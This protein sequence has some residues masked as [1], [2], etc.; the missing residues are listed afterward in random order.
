MLEIILVILSF[1]LGA[2]PIIDWLNYTLTGQRLEKLGTGNVSVS[3]AFYHGGRLVGI[4]AVLSEAAKGIVVVLLARLLFP[5]VGVWEIIALIA[6]VL[7][8]YCLGRGAGT[9]NVFWGIITH[10]PLAAALVF[11]LGGLSFLG[12]RQRQLSKVFI[13]IFLVV[14]IAWRHPQQPA[15]IIAT[16][17][18]SLLLGWVISNI[19]DDLNLSTQGVNR[20]SQGM[21]NFLR[22]QSGLISLEKSLK[23]TEVGQK[24][25]NL[26]LLKSWGYLVPDGWVLLADEKIDF[27][28]EWLQ[29]SEDNPYIVRSSAVG[30]DDQFSSAAGQYQSILNI[31]NQAELKRAIAVCRDSYLSESAQQYRQDRGQK[32]A[33]MAI[34][35]QKQ[36]KGVLSG[37]V[38]SRDPLEQ[39]DQAVV[40]EAY[41]GDASLV[42]SGKVTPE[43]HRVMVKDNAK[44]NSLELSPEAVIE[45]IATIAREIENRAFG[46]PEDLE[47]TYDGQRLW[48]LQSR[49][50]TTLQPLWTR[51]IAAEVIP[52]IIKPLTWS[53]N[54]P[55]TCGV[56]GEIFTIVL[57][58]RAVGLNFEDT[59]TLHWGRAYFNATLLG[60]I[61]L[62][63]GLPRESLEFLTRGAKMTKPPLL[64]TLVNIPGLLRLLGRE[65]RLVTDFQRD[66]RLYFQPLLT[67]LQSWPSADLPGQIPAILSTLQRATYYSILAPLSLALRQGILKVDLEDL[68]NSL[69]PEVESLRSLAE[70]ARDTA[71]IIP[72]VANSEE[73][74]NHLDQPILDKFKALVSRYAYL[75]ETATDISVPR[76]GDNPSLVEELF[77]QFLLYP[78][79]P[80]KEIPAN[81]A[82]QIVQ[83][84]L[85]LKGRVTEVYSQLLAYLRW[86][87]LALGEEWVR[88]GLLES[89]DDI[90]WLEY[91]EITAIIADKSKFNPKLIQERQTQWREITQVE[92]VPYVVYGNHPG[93]LTPQNYTCLDQQLR[94]IGASWGEKTGIIKIIR[95]LEEIKEINQEM[96]VVVPYT[97]SGWGPFLVRAGGIISEVGGRLSHGAIIAREY[98]IPAIM[99][100]QNATQVL[101]DGQ[102]VRING[103]QG[104]V[105]ILA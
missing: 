20:E 49:P 26:S 7:G 89:K 29:V 94:G 61:F 15:L 80:T 24:A 102:R 81:F 18:L 45:A 3:A 86:S 25:A 48:L 28:L 101:K 99:D 77:Y 90:F 6:L 63:M 52:G 74:F 38:F 75:S 12:W 51:K 104:V 58:N 65:W 31:T 11:C 71:K 66:D 83:Q 78:Q 37:V 56:W 43:S 87:F 69:T 34:I 70:L 95:N 76:W 67:S 23:P 14:V 10:D 88:L 82:T 42:V 5:G 98:G 68:D 55:L 35:I 84:R 93:D 1:T 36:V 50:I 46:I 54:R 97:D 53:I 105:E 30:E 27:D 33:K 4:L 60:D 103:Q 16:I 57:G 21:F 40:V 8:R 47:W 73:L 100:L 22:G 32:S 62:R 2:L 72:S 41:P 44:V 13:L 9:T 92:N 59:A 96:I 39:G 64:S 85:N 79:P 91:S 19:P 17:V